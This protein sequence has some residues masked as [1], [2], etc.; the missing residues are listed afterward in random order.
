MPCLNLIN[1]ALNAAKGYSNNSAGCK[2][3]ALH[4]R[5]NM[6]TEKFLLPFSMLERKLRSIS[7]A[8][9]KSSWLSFCL[10][11]SWAIFRPMDFNVAM[12][13]SMWNLAYKDRRLYSTTIIYV[14]FVMSEFDVVKRLC[15]DI[16]KTCSE[17]DI[18][19]ITYFYCRILTDIRESGRNKHAEHIPQYGVSQYEAGY[20]KKTIEIYNSSFLKDNP[21]R[22]AY[23]GGLLAM[24]HM[25]A[26]II[27]QE[28]YKSLGGLRAM[29]GLSPF[30]TQK[31]MLAGGINAEIDK[32]LSFE[33]SNDWQDLEF[34]LSN[35]SNE[36]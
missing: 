25:R 6:L 29:L 16:R 22:N 1:Q 5:S 14:G 21:D 8:P 10:R 33:E 23:Y 36:A 9:A 4:R 31:A 12:P 15:S 7:A 3:S 18:D 13:R 34:E 24:Y 17:D 32:L 26:C 28:A 2:S 35:P 30:D 27:H 11:R 19:R 20:L